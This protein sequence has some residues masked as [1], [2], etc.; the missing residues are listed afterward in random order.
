M[1]PTRPTN[2]M[3]TMTGERKKTKYDTILTAISPSQ[4]PRLQLNAVR[5]WLPST[6][7]VVAFGDVRNPENNP[8]IEIYPPKK[9]S[10]TLWE[11]LEFQNAKGSRFE[12]VAIC[13]PNLVLNDTPSALFDF[14]AGAGTGRAW[15]FYVPS[16]VQGAAHDFFVTTTSVIPHLV[17]AVPEDLTMEGTDWAVWLHEWLTIN[18][19]AHRYLD[20]TKFDLVT[21]RIAAPPEP[22]SIFSIAG[23]A[24]R[25]LEEIAPARPWAR[26]HVT[27]IDAKPVTLAKAGLSEKID[28]EVAIEEQKPVKATETPKKGRGRPKGS[29]NK[30]K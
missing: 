6:G 30:K 9:G 27:E 22:P 20:A 28:D 21:G 18:M 11:L 17:K 12:V 7:S 3:V 15:A 5:Q 8:G 29:R 26:Q 14:L 23:F 2:I 19:P 10:V 25:A 1:E 24:D 13:A 16:P 4:P